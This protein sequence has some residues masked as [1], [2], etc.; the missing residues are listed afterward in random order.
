MI[1]VFMPK[2]T[3][4]KEMAET[5]SYCKKLFLWSKSPKF[6]V[7]SCI[8]LNMHAPSE[9][10][11][12]YSKDSFYEELQQILGHFPKYHMNI[13]LGDF[14]ATVGS[15]NIF[16]LT[17]G[18]KSPHQDSNDN[19]V[20]IINFVTSKSLVVNSMM[21]PQVRLEVRL[22]AA[23]GD[24]TVSTQ[25]VLFGP[26]VRHGLWLPPIISRERPC[27]SSAG[28]P[29]QG[30]PATSPIEYRCTSTGSARSYPTECRVTP[31]GGAHNLLDHWSPLLAKE[32]ICRA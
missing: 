4:S 26:I 10:Q 3:T 13:L 5:R 20:R 25:A 17:T 12:D 29:R 22:A 2:G 16:K 18:N 14:N 21:F 9:E 6:W 1:A 32:G 23:G 31:T 19:G 30:A 15:E 28:A 24:P 11:S 8:V 27:C 7:A